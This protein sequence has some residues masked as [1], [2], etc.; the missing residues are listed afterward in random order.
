M[1]IFSSVL[2]K[3]YDEHRR[4]L[5]WRGLQDAYR[6]WVSEIILQQ[7]RIDQGIDYYRR[8]VESFPDI[9]ALAAASE[10]EVLRAWQGLGY[11]S[12]ARNMHQTALD[13]A[14]NHNGS[15]PQS[16]A[17]LIK[18]KGIG[19]YTAAAIASIVFGEKVPALDGNV[20]RV[21]ARYFA[22]P[23]SIDTGLGK[24]TIRELAA[25]LVPDK[26]PGEFN[27][28][29]M[30][31]GSLVC[32]PVNPLCNDCIFQDHCLALQRQSVE[33]YPV[34]NIK[35]KVRKRYFNYFLFETTGPNGEPR[36]FIQKRTGND[37]WKN[38]YE[39]PL[40]ETTSMVSEDELFTSIWW[41]A[42]VP[43]DKDVVIRKVMSPVVHQLTHQQIYA[44]LIRVRIFFASADNL[45]NR[46]ILSDD[47][48]FE[49]LAK[50]RLIEILLAQADE[51]PLRIHYDP[52]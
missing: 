3:W 13:I 32:K 36:F 15:F 21:L 2:L 46:F 26:R 28:A 10:D 41:K 18:L 24:K 44:R 30:D 17:E 50:P 4:N 47:E 20:Y 43:A 7:T 16:S 35:R 1:M 38:M 42:L 37:I 12:R 33:K 48:E 23:H 14:E 31:F 49:G 40:L 39:L 25:Q 19:E 34:R 29:M 9:Y 45:I 11:Y 5:P 51:T 6:V 8:F 22:V 52:D 27:Q